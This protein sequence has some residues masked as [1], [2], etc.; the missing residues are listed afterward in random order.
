MTSFD[1]IT[2]E[3]FRC[4]LESDYDEMT[5]C[6]KVGAWK[7]VHVL[8]GSIIEALLIDFLLAE[9][10]VSREDALK[11]DLGSALTL[12]R[13]KKIISQR[14]FDLSSVVRSYRNLIHPGRTIRLNERVSQDSAKVAEALVSIVLTE[15][16]R[17]KR[18]HYGYTAEQI[19]SKLE[20]DSSADAILPHLMQKTNSVEIERL[21]LKDPSGCLYAHS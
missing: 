4:S 2:S 16:E 9:A 17:Q 3:D 1:F 10:I 13:D 11:L 19:V 18:E 8:A 12:G 7:A 14:T 6:L 20:R 5:A 15:V 21:L